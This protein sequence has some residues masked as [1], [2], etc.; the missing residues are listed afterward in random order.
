VTA[1]LAKRDE[2][3]K[4]LQMSTEHAVK[5]VD[6]MVLGSKAFEPEVSVGGSFVKMIPPP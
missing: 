1:D 3:V 5:C 4:S 6:D 2:E